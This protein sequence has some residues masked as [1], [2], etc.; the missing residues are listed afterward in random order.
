[1]GLSVASMLYTRIPLTKQERSTSQSS[2]RLPLS[3]LSPPAVQ[4]GTDMTR[5]LRLNGDQKLPVDVG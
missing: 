2:S 4:F 3:I 1:M 5:T